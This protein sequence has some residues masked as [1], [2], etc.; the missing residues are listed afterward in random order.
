MHFSRIFR[1]AFHP[2]ACSVHP[3]LATLCGVLVFLEMIFMNLKF[4]KFC[5]WYL[6]MNRWNR[7]RGHSAGKSWFLLPGCVNIQAGKGNVLVIRFFCRFTWWKWSANWTQGIFIKLQLLFRKY[8]KQRT[9]FNIYRTDIL[10]NA[11]HTTKYLK[12]SKLRLLRRFF[13]KFSAFYF[14]KQT[15]SW[16]Y[17]AYYVLAKFRKS[18]LNKNITTHSEAAEV[19]DKDTVGGSK[20]FL[21]DKAFSPSGIFST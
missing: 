13:N 7:S 3:A 8:L 12:F 21:G 20:A 16:N 19:V 15:S 18:N 4:S 17:T 1:W 10:Y 2:P 5:T 9:F 14:K 6:S 11:K